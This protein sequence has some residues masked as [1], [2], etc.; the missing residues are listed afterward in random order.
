LERG[1]E[2]WSI[3][4]LSKREDDLCGDVVDHHGCFQ[5]PKKSLKRAKDTN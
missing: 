3:K 4:Q 5:E 1:I 2:R